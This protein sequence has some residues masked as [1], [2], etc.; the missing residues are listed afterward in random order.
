MLINFKLLNDNVMDEDQLKDIIDATIYEYATNK[1]NITF[2]DFLK[3]FEEDFVF[4]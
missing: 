3:I 1:E 4:N 2:D